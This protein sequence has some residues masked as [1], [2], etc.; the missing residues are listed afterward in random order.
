[1]ILSHNRLWAQAPVVSFTG[2]LVVGVPLVGRTAAT[3][4]LVP[5]GVPRC[6]SRGARV[7]V[8]R[9][10]GKDVAVEPRG[11][12]ALTRLGGKD[13]AVEPRGPVAFTRLGGKDAAVVPRGPVAVSRPGVK[14]AAVKPRR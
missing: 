4:W 13:V 11:P 12:V 14:Y 3:R 10:C 7:A 9:L 5:D 8:T 2:A 1:V 6:L